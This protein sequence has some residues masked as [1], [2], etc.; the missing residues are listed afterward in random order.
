MSDRVVCDG[1]GDKND[2]KTIERTFMTE[3]REKTMAVMNVETLDQET[4]RDVERM[5][6]LRVSTKHNNLW[7]RQLEMKRR[8]IGELAGLIGFDG[9]KTEV[10]KEKNLEAWGKRCTHFFNKKT[11]RLPFEEIDNMVWSRLDE[12]IEKWCN[13]NKVFDEITEEEIEEIWRRD[14]DDNQEV[15]RLNGK[16]AWETAKRVCHFI[17]SHEEL[18]HITTFGEYR[19]VMRK[20]MSVIKEAHNTE[21]K[22]RW[23]AKKEICEERRTRTQRAKALISQ[24]KRGEMRKEDISRRVE[25]IFGKG[26]GKKSKMKPLSRRSPKELLRCQKEKRLLTNG[27]E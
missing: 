27:K 2:L 3:M 17:S 21:R 4:I 16:Y 24:I 1:E 26:A 13:E 18:I 6:I 8:E 22:R 15:I 23:T 25:L 14:Q 9:V 5:V 10:E 12:G 20:V 11:K 7:M 19:N